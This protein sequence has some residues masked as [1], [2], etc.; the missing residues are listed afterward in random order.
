MITPVKNY[1]ALLHK[2]KQHKTL[3]I[4]DLHLGWEI[5]LTKK[6]IHI[7]S[8]TPKILQKLLQLVT[9]TKPDT[10]IILGDVK[11]SIAK[12][13]PSEWRDIPEFF[14]TVE[15]KVSDIQVIRGNHDGNLEPLLPPTIQLHPSTGITLNTA[16]LF[17]GH[18]WP[19]KKLLKCNTLIMGHAHP[20][21]AFRDSLGFQMT[22]PVWIKAKCNTE[23]LA[24][25]YLKGKHVKT[26]TNPIEAIQKIFN[27]KPRVKQLLIMPC[28][29]DF[30]G[31][32]PINKK[33]KQKS[34]I[35]PVLRSE[36]INV[37][38]AE[39]YML[40]GAFLGTIEQLKA[41]N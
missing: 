23:K 20:T 16:G 33:H 4:A 8:Q 7:P 26:D 38:K 22:T 32:R 12:A 2:Q 29:N 40:D 31:G 27:I 19:A 17:H 15:T 1:P 41:L 35:S 34:Y 36:A 5:N 30:L 37:N 21:V 9:T 18:T 10:L 14:K 39:V 11:H 13:E 25:T 3:I 28:F 24:N 6:G